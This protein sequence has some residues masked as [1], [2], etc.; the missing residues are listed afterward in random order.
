MLIGLGILAGVGAFF[1]SW[2]RWAAAVSTSFLSALAAAVSVV[3]I[4]G[5]ISDS[6]LSAGFWWL[7]GAAVVGGALA[8]WAFGAIESVDRAK[9]AIFAVV[10]LIL[11]SIVVGSSGAVEGDLLGSFTDQV[12]TNFFA[13]GL[14]SMAVT[15]LGLSRPGETRAVAVFI[16]LAVIL[17]SAFMFQGG[18]RDRLMAMLFSAGA[19]I[20][21]ST[22]LFVGANKWF[23]LARARWP[24]FGMVTGGVV[25]AVLSVLAWANRLVKWQIG[26]GEAATDATIWLIP[27]AVVLGAVY[28]GAIASNQNPR[29]RLFIGVGGGAVL[30]LIAAA[31]VSVDFYPAIRAVPLIVWPIGLAGLGAALSSVES[32]RLRGIVFGL[33]VVAAVRAFQG[34]AHVPF[35]GY[36]G[37]GVLGALFAQLSSDTLWRGATFGGAVGWLTATLVVPDLGSGAIAETIMALAVFGSLAG[38]RLALNREATKARTEDLTLSARTVIFLF[39]SLAFIGAT[40]VIPTIRTMYLSF[41]DSR[42]ELYVGWKNYAAIFADKGIVNTSEW[43]EI[44]SSPW[45]FAALG[46]VLIGILAGIIAGRDRGQKF[47]G[48]GT[49]TGGMAA[50]VFLFAFAVFSN[51]RG[52]IFNNLWWLFTVTIVATA[53]GLAIAVLADRAKGESFAKS[54]IFMPMAV[55]F[56]GAGIIWRFMYVARDYR[57]EQTGVLNS[58]WVW[59]GDISQSQ[60]PRLVALIVLAVAIVAMLSGAWILWR[61]GKGSSAVGLGVVALPLFVPLWGFATRSIGGFVV[62]DDGSVIAGPIQFL[63]T[64]PYNNV[65][66]MIVLIWIQT[67]F[68]MVILSAA[69]KAVPAELIEASKVDGATESQTFWRITIPQIVPTIGVVVTTLIVLV[70]KVFDIVKVMTNGNFDTQVL[71]NEM[72]QR[73]IV[74]FNLGL[75]SALAVLLFISVVPVM[76][77]NIRRTSAE[78]A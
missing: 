56:V 78:V 36:L 14:I 69:I 12:W 13:I 6:E 64:G 38:W 26:S 77:I 29:T 1:M 51:L 70:M 10:G 17:N 5:A 52:T 9:R 40:L 20:L 2:K 18:T 41:L 33:V 25:G 42:A 65:A 15:F 59:I 72:F 16:G 4:G 60:T 24:V 54:L 39:P 19:A 61:G 47:A 44:F 31:F 34:D 76:Y 57:K 27:L 43:R 55:S 58:L 45:F 8:W 32:K 73:A 23:D 3:V 37:L 50:G 28:G 63:S 75:G 74:E 49:A 53:A 35:E 71:A 48:G 22:V 62:R 66:L 7:M 68:T 11:A 30:G 67:G 21:A 46:A